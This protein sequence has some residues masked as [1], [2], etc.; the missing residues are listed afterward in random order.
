M[1]SLLLGLEIGAHI[2]D[3]RVFLLE[4]LH[5]VLLGQEWSNEEKKVVRKDDVA[6]NQQCSKHLEDNRYFISLI[7]KLQYSQLSHRD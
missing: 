3:Q 4:S 2:F 5:F 6:Q 1:S 7:Q